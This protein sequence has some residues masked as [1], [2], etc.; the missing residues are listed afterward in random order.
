MAKYPYD[1]HKTFDFR[2]SGTPKH[3]VRVRSQIS[4][5]PYA[6]LL[7]TN[8]LNTLAMALFWID[9]AASVAANDIKQSRWKKSD[10]QGLEPPTRSKRHLPE[11]AYFR[12]RHTCIT[13]CQAAREAVF[14]GGWGIAIESA[15]NAGQLIGHSRRVNRRLMG[16]TVNKHPTTIRA[17]Q[18]K[19]IILG[20]QRRRDY[21]AVGRS[22]SAARTQARRPPISGAFWLFAFHS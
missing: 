5:A 17:E 14:R 16:R 7:T 15:F 11:W 19:V 4:K 8:E 2:Q 21:A 9:Y 13:Q 18:N 12:D 3:Y 20:C 22:K 10:L 6:K 1:F